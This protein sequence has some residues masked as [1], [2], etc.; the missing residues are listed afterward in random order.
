MFF[1]LI[2]ALCSLLSTY[3]FIRLNR[4]A[5]IVGL[6]ATCLNGLLYWHKGIYAD[7]MLEGFYFL[8]M[9]YGWFKWQDSANHVSMPLQLNK[10]SRTQW[11]LLFILLGIIFIIIYTLLIL[12]THSSVAIL[13]ASTTSLSLVAQWLMCHKIIA[14]WMLWFVTDTLYIL[15]YLTKNLPFHSLLMVIYMGMAI[16]GY[17]TW[18][19]AFKNSLST[20]HMKELSAQGTFNS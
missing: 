16:V 8:N 20:K 19:R 13:D 10:L 9:G 11:L 2:G 18:T 15:I 1:D 3:Y 6:F 12:F 7:M 14:T 4:K 17:I 5:W